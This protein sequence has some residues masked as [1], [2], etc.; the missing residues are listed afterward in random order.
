MTSGVRRGHEL[1]LRSTWELNMHFVVVD[2]A[3][4]CL[5]PQLRI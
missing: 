4:C 1:N 2:A 5:E 3:E